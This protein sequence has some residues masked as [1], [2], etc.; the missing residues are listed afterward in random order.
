MKTQ[1]RFTSLIFLLFFVCQAQAQIPSGEMPAK[2]V[3]KIK[4]VFPTFE[5]SQTI[6]IPDPLTDGAPNS[7]VWTLW[8]KK[9]KHLGFAR[10]IHTTTGCNMSCLPLHFILVLDK[11]KKFKALIEIDLLTKKNHAPFTD[12]DRLKLNL[13][14]LSPPASFKKPTQPLDVID[15]ITAETKLEYQGDVIKEA[16]LTSFRSYQYLKQTQNSLP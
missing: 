5:K 14:L 2:F 16:A 1:I 8:G 9:N 12:E 15:V 11:L 3:N 6:Q 4:K 13:I 10:E 7:S